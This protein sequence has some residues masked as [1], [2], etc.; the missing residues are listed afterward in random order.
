[1][2]LRMVLVAGALL[3]AGIVVLGTSWEGRQI[4]PGV[5]RDGVTLTQ[6]AVLWVVLAAIGMAVAAPV[7]GWRARMT[8]ITPLLLWVAWQLRASALGPPAFVIYAVPTL[9]VWLA[10]LAGVDWIRRSWHEA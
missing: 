2:R 6:W 8:A 5:W 1:M 3:G 10:A 4:A 7:R 9:V